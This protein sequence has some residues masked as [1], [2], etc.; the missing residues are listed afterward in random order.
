MAISRVIPQTITVWLWSV[1][2]TMRFEL[3]IPKSRLEVANAVHEFE[4]ILLPRAQ[5][6][7]EVICLSVVVVRKSPDLDI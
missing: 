6:R 4:S 5:G 7:G 3:E 2:E 1:I